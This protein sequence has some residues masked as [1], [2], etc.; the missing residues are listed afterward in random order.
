MLKFR[1]SGPNHPLQI[2]IKGKI[3]GLFYSSYDKKRHLAAYVPHIQPPQ[4]AVCG[5][6][7]AHF[8]P[9][10]DTDHLC[11]KCATIIRRRLRNE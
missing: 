7:V 8:S 5:D 4:A 1:D 11:Q 10:R 6:L 9:T 2:V 3:Y